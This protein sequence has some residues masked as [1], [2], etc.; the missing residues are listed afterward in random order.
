[1]I[2]VELTSS[3]DF[4]YFVRA[5]AFSSKTVEVDIN[6]ETDM[7]DQVQE[8]YFFSKTST[9]Y[10]VVDI[11]SNKIPLGKVI[12]KIEQQMLD[13]S[14]MDVTPSAAIN[15]PSYAGRLE[16]L[17][18]V[19]E[20]ISS[21]G[22]TSALGYYAW[23]RYVP[24]GSAGVNW[25]ADLIGDD[26]IS[27][28][29]NCGPSK[30]KPDSNHKYTNPSDTD[31]ISGTIMPHFPDC[32][33]SDFNTTLGNS[34]SLT[35]DINAD[36]TTIDGIIVNPV[37]A[38][39]FTSSHADIMRDKIIYGPSNLGSGKS[40]ESTITIVEDPKPIGS[41]ASKFKVLF[42]QDFN[43][44]DDYNTTTDK[45]FTS[46]KELG[47][48]PNGAKILVYYF[49]F[50]VN[51]FSK[52]HRYSTKA[53]VTYDDMP[54]DANLGGINF[55][56]GC[57]QKDVS[58][59]FDFSFTNSGSNPITAAF[60][61]KIMVDGT[62]IK[63]IPYNVLAG[64][65]T[66]T[67]SFTKTFSSEQSLSIIL[68]SMPGE[69]NTSDNARVFP[70]SP[71]TTCTIDNGPEVITGDFHL[72][73]TKMMFGQSNSVLPDNVSVSGGAGCKMTQF[74][75]V[76]SQGSLIDDT[77]GITSVPS[78]QGFTGPPYPRGMGEGFV[79]VTMKIVTSCGTTK[80]VG[81]KSFEITVASGNHA[82]IF[83]PG[84]F[85]GNNVNRYPS[86]DEA[87]LGDYIDLGIIQDRFAKPETPYDP[88]G[89]GIV[90]SWDF[91]GSSDPF[92]RK[93]DTDFG[94]WEHDEHFKRI[95]ADVLGIHT[96]Y[97]TG[98][99]T[100]GAKTE[101]KPATITIVEPNPVAVCTAPAEVKA[102]HPLAVDA[103]HSGKSRSPVNGRTID[104]SKDIWINKLNAYPN[105]S[106]GDVTVNVTLSKVTDN[107]GLESRNPSTCSI[108]V[109]PDLPPVAK[110]IAPSLGIRGDEY[111]VLNDSSSVDGDPIT[112]VEYKMK[113]DAN[114]NGFDDDSWVSIS[115]TNPKYIFKPDKV[116]K[117]QFYLKVIEQY[118]ASAEAVS[119]TMNVINQAP[120][121]SFDLIGNSPNPDPKPSTLYTAGDILKFWSLFH[122]N[123]TQQLK[124]RSYM[125]HNMQGSLLA[126]LGK[127]ADEQTWG[128]N[129]VRSMG[130]F[131]S[132]QAYTTTLNDMGYG[133]NGLS[134][135]KPMISPTAGYSQP[136]FFPTEN[137]D[138]G[139]AVPGGTLLQSDK[140]HIYFSDGNYVDKFSRFYALNKSKIGRYTNKIVWT[141][142]PWGG[143]ATGLLTH[144]WLD[145]NPYD[146]VIK[147][148]SY[149]DPV[150]KKEVVVPF[151]PQGTSFP[152]E[153]TKTVSE[154]PP[155]QSSYYFAE[156][157]IYQ[158]FSKETPRFVYYDN[159][160]DHGGIKNAYNSLT[161]ACSYRA[162]DG[163]LIRCFDVAPKAT[164]F[165]IKGPNLVVLNDKSLGYSGQTGIDTIVYDVNGNLI[166]SNEFQTNS[167]AFPV[168]YEM[169]SYYRPTNSYYS[170]VPARYDTA[171]CSYRNYYNTQ[172]YKGLDNDYYVYQ[173]RECTAS[174]GTPLQ[175][176]H[177]T[178]VNYPQLEVGIYV[179]KFD[180]DNKLVWRAR[181]GGNAMSYSSSMNSDYQ[182]NI[183]TMIVNPFANQII[184]KTMYNFSNL[185][186]DETHTNVFNTIDM[187][188]G[189]VWGAGN[190]N[191]ITPN[192]HINTNENYVYGSCA[193][194]IYGNC[195]DLSTGEGKVITGSYGVVSGETKLVST[196]AFSEYLG[197]GLLVSAYMYN[198]WITGNSSPPY[199]GTYLYM[200]KGDPVISEPKIP[201]FQLGQYK[202]NYELKDTEFSFDLKSEQTNVDKE[203]FGFSFRMQDGMNRYA[204]E[205]D[206][207][208]VYVSKYQAGIRTVLMSSDFIILD[209]K[210][211]SVKI[212]MINN[213]LFV[214]INNVNYFKMSDITFSK[215]YFGPF[216]N[217]SFVTYSAIASK[218]INETDVWSG[219]YVIIDEH[220]GEN[221]LNYDNIHF[222]DP[223]NDP[224]AG[225]YEWGYMHM[226]MFLN[227]Q[228]VSSLSGKSFSSGQ[229]H[230]DKVGKYE[231]SLKAKDDPHPAINYKYPDLTFNAYRENS[232]T[233]KKTIIAH[234]RP[235]AEFS[236]IVDDDGNVHW[237][238]SSYDPDRYNPATGEFSPGYEVNKGIFQERYYY[239]DPDGKLVSEQ[240]KT[241]TKAGTY[242]VGLQ[243]KD[244]YGAWSY[245]TEHTLEIAVKPNHKPM[246]QLIS[247]NGTEDVP[248]YAGQNSDPLLQWK[249]IDTDPDTTF[250]AYE[251]EV[252]YK[253]LSGRDVGK[254]IR[255]ITTGQKAGISKLELGS[256][257]NGSGYANQDKKF[258]WRVRVKD[259]TAW[260]EWS[261]Y[262]WFQTNRPPVAMLT[263]PTGT[264]ASP[265]F[266][267]SLTP[268]IS[269][270]QSDPD[271][272]AILYFEVE[273]KDE[274]GNL[275]TSA[276]TIKYAYSNNASGS[277]N[278]TEPLTNGEKYQVRVRVEDSHLTWS[279][280]TNVGWMVA[281]RP[282]TA[283]MR[284]PDGTQAN[285]THIQTVRPTLQWSQIDQ[286]AGT[287]FTYFQIQITNEANDTIVL[288]TGSYS[289]NTA[290]T[291]GYWTVDRDLPAG[292]KLRVRVRVFDG[293]A[294]SDYSP[295]TWLYINRAPSVD[296]DWSPKPVWE[297]DRVQINNLSIDLDGDDLA[298]EW[299][300]QDPNLI[301]STFTSK[302]IAYPFNQPGNYQVSLTVTDGYLSATSTKSIPAAPLT[303]QSDVN[304]TE[305]WLALHEKNG[306]QTVLAPK[307]F[308]S[309]EI[310][311]VSSRSSSAPVD[312]VTAWM[313]TTG[314]DGHSLYVTQKL[315][316]SL[317]NGTFYS[318]DLFD[319]RFQSYAEGLPPGLQ[320]IHFRIRYRNGVV[321]TE[322]IPVNMIGNVNKSVGVHRVQ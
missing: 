221:E 181:T 59:S 8:P 213:E 164:Q 53:R 50:K 247:Y 313:D 98:M 220:T 86:I 101:R 81:P 116:G 285:P 130:T 210:K 92:I 277:F 110:I 244:E 78:T 288:D 63:T 267:D 138:P 192:F 291:L 322:D 45:G 14:Y 11:T 119:T 161:M 243:V 219:D 34:L 208:N 180:K 253:A 137:G 91:K 139:G 307:D 304:Y 300:V 169:K 118:G 69:K 163:S 149:N 205:W 140:I 56:P 37:A 284:V 38:L 67:G 184:T 10:G 320:M 270:N 203:L 107:T 5:A 312:E 75:Y 276:S 3:L 22:N 58:K 217:K 311:V 79:D 128:V 64:G 204:L 30:G 236:H 82:P 15:Q 166:D 237:S 228:G 310:F 90:Y 113:Y 271:S 193:N 146:Y 314:L 206:G 254:T 106:S 111:D 259:E 252:Y 44:Q 153:G 145:G 315:T 199:G 226:P 215:G 200:D 171:S 234:R 191:P 65:A 77:V 133:K 218:S 40:D 25:Y 207:S 62:E 250:T 260:S 263:Y 148:P 61:V 32:R 293:H 99:D 155:S 289:Q 74:G 20:A 103:I 211:Y 126:G 301:T 122:T 202:S 224:I 170:Y 156:N 123:T 46:S 47:S 196:K 176:N 88:E 286:D 120:K 278:V 2:A 31:D 214:F 21:I 89:D 9:A 245:N 305:K 248:A 298:Y 132:A 141:P 66:A 308:Y 80:V 143:P 319:I 135:Y 231:V 281:N 7:I 280:W 136:L 83:Q 104:H 238:Q 105:A 294:W 246:V 198:Q 183:Q 12:K 19:S 174:N 6:Y 316:V 241:A 273:T 225:T 223:E 87:V 94:F 127:G 266:M 112:V 194:T 257:Q 134:P 162:L 197:D 49:A 51:V 190:V 296:F 175:S 295:Q 274:N 168:T 28:N 209:H 177:I 154:I 39:P 292:Q 142:N 70:I 48:P 57:V 147:T 306:D 68:D 230:F 189:A 239:I 222:D 269:W 144:H 43:F 121:V 115:G 195:S 167:A 321:K 173:I 279:E 212:R 42:N 131:V 29:V 272:D 262:G 290:S 13:G 41:D 114:N 251:V 165:I 52:T 264:L 152:V 73:K 129:T 232:N 159:D 227:N 185:W 233:Y 84:W 27:H 16:E 255:Y 71:Q 216:S 261:E 282:P 96:A 23:Y 33:S 95:K 24:G 109:H 283:I 303:I 186:S 201:R 72:E 108:I 158:V 258:Y 299:K 17:R 287:V 317:E 318:G 102:N 182:D 157:N 54:T 265:T 93:L 76:F 150:I 302:N 242:L 275:V 240:L 125:W 256:F 124:N 85:N 297:G 229:M 188:S 178:S 249:Q 60:N 309:G 187:A 172:T 4:G 151:Y 268:T 160:S 179:A 235:I 55:T 35:A 36:Y 97:V 26:G 100:R 18:G 1:M 117:Y